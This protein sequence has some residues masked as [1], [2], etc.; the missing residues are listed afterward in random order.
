[1]CETPLISERFVWD[2]V[3]G[4]TV[5]PWS[6]PPLLDDALLLCGA[7]EQSQAAVPFERGELALPHEMLTFV[8]EAGS[9]FS[10]EVV[11]AVV[12]MEEDRVTVDTEIRDLVKVMPGTWEAS[13]TIEV[14]SLNGTGWEHGS[15]SDTMHVARHEWLGL[16]DQR[17]RLRTEVW[18]AAR[19]L[20]RLLREGSFTVFD[21]VRYR[22]VIAASGFPSVWATV[23][24]DLGDV[25]ILRLL[26]HDVDEESLA[27]LL[28]SAT[29]ASTSATSFPGTAWDWLFPEDRP[30]ARAELRIQPGGAGTEADV[31]VDFAAAAT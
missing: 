26:L 19:G 28:P 22:Q 3:R 17:S 23:L 24:A 18:I 4:A 2:A 30:P 8:L 25:E 1:M 10:Y 7:C 9:P 31:D 14:F 16:A 29:V 12:M 13:R 5:S 11:R 21:L 20:L 6:E 15:D 27:R